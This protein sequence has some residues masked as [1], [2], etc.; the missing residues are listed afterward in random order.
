[1]R[2]TTL[3]G[4]M[5]TVATGLLDALPGPARA[6][7]SRPFADETGRRWIEYRP[8]P[9]PGACLAD[10][11]RVARKATHRLLATALSPHAYAQAATIMA[12]EEVLDRREEW[13]RGRHSD[14]YRIVVFGD[15]ARDD[16]WS[17]RFEGHHLSVTMTVAGDGVAPAP[18]FLGVNPA[19][20]SYA[21]RPV[22]RPL[23][24]EEDL[25]RAL[26]DA[27]GPDGRGMAIVADEAPADIRSG[28]RSRFDRRIEPP[29]IRAGGLGP[30]GRA[31][32]DHLVALYL[33]RLPPELA[34][35]EAARVSRSDLYFAWE[36]P[37]R[38]GG[39]HYY[40]IQGEDL[41]IEYDNTSDDGNHAHSVLRRPHGD[42]GAD[43]LAEH[44]ATAHS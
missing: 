35:Q 41:L 25:A 42:F 20:V 14:D 29:G 33:D 40:R 11:D 8:L 13:R 10:L 34:R 6:L 3:A 37:T 23:G 19:T 31:L 38:P 26:L 4:E 28:T 15:P 36:G 18:L 5:R 17:W 7:A 30:T 9:R 43:L 12:L 16:H 24:P 21:G 22:S 27:I 39:R 1:M 44:H 32:L 2:N